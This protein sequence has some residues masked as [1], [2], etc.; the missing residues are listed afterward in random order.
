MQIKGSDPQIT[1]HTNPKVGSKSTNRRQIQKKNYF[2]IG[3]NILSR[4]SYASSQQVSEVFPAICH[5]KMAEKRK[6]R[7]QDGLKQK[8]T[9]QTSLGFVQNYLWIQ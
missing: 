9:S 5:S 1:L 7:V 4:V 6:K 2:E 3:K 8:Y